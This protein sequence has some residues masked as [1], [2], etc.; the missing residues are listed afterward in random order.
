VKVTVDMKFSPN[1]VLVI[2]K[3]VER[4]VS[5]LVLEL[6]EEARSVAFALAPKRTGRLAESIQVVQTQTGVEVVVTAPYAAKVERNAQFFYRAV[7]AAWEKTPTW[8]ER[9]KIG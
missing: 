9:I 6:A 1:E 7:Q 3:K 5:E 4:E 8:L 2:L